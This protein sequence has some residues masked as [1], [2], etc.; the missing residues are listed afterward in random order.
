MAGLI[1]SNFSTLIKSV[2]NNKAS[3][4][5]NVIGLSV[6]ITVSLL[7]FIYVD[8]EN[9]YDDF[10]E[11]SKTLY[12]V[13]ST[14]HN[15]NE[16]VNSWATSSFGYGPA[17]K[18]EFPEIVDYTLL[19][20]INS[21]K[22]VS[23]GDKKFWEDNVY[24]VNHNFFEMFSYPLLRGDK[25]E[26]LNEP[27][28]VVITKR[29][30]QKYFGNEDPINKILKVSEYGKTYECK[31]TGIMAKVPVNSNLQFDILVSFKSAPKFMHKHWYWHEAYTYV[32]VNSPEDI[33]E[34]EKRFPAMSEKYKTRA[35]MKELTWGIKLVPVEDIHLQPTKAYE[36]EV[37]GNVKMM[38]LLRLI[39]YII[40]LI[41]WINF[42][43][44][45]LANSME[46]LKETFVRKV[47]GSSRMQII[48]QFLTDFVVFNFVAIV[49]SVVVLLIT[50]PIFS[51]FVGKDLSIIKFVKSDLVGLKLSVFALCMMVAGLIP[52][53]LL[54]NLS[55]KNY[56]SNKLKNLNGDFKLINVLIMVQFVLAIVLV[57]GSIIIS[58]QI[59]F[60]LNK[61]KGVDIENTIVLKVPANI[62]LPP[63]KLEHYKEELKKSPSIS[64]VASSSSIP[65][66]EVANFLEIKR[67]GYTEK[68]ESLFEMLRADYGYIKGYGLQL[69]AGRDFDK[70]IIN[71]INSVV[72]NEE[73]VRML[74]FDNNEEALNQKINLGNL[75][76]GF[77]II[78]VVGN[79]HQQP[80]MYNYTPIVFFIAPV[81]TWIKTKYISIKVSPN[82]DMSVLT[83]IREIT[84]D[85][86]PN[87]DFDI[88]VLEDSY[89]SQYEGVFVFKMIFQTFTMICVLIA[90]IGLFGISMLSFKTNSKAVA[91]HKIH[92]APTVVQ[93][94]LLT[95]KYL[96]ILLISFAIGIPVCMYLLRVWLNNYPYSIDITAM[97]FIAAFIMLF[98]VLNISVS[99]LL[100]KISVLNTAKILKA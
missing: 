16:L 58:Q 95:K 26:V 5:L 81:H 54:S 78:G 80:L 74:G 61:E 83:Q 31:V 63:K 50:L 35:S 30:A 10:H 2:L 65:S 48:I 17:M 93:Y 7:I 37:K 46:R 56:L 9:S 88:Q 82:T 64:N 49:I 76:E 62:K 100:I 19:N 91:V 86:F 45:S 1:H 27:G 87:S 39:G 33:E 22:Y 55:P 40:I 42:V 20:L 47:I 14:F 21:E 32:K 23:R 15:G 73:A 85:F 52:A 18:E 71:D 11:N 28:S 51:S 38:N 6:G 57:S 97:P 89:E 69:A 36:R 25:A 72:I 77:K 96:F 24:L 75:K 4:I 66:K 92:G 8:F 79:Y 68:P 13:E 94:Y 34:I 41:S 29:I 12:R 3:T 59:G 60:L 53:I 67:A 44:I 98:V 70:R 99:Y 84:N 43:N 90:C